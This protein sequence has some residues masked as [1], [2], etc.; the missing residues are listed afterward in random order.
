MGILSC[1]YTSTGALPSSKAQT[2][3]FFP[4]VEKKL[5]ALGTTKIGIVDGNAS[6][7]L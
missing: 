4:L 5:V 3:P 1:I 7:D 2:G 6:I